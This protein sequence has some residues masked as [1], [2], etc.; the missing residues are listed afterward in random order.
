M[1]KDLAWQI[2]AGAIIV[3]VIWRLM[4]APMKIINDI[5]RERKGEY[6]LTLKG[7]NQHVNKIQDTLTE[8][9]KELKPEQALT[10]QDIKQ[11]IFWS[12]N[13]FDDSMIGGITRSVC[14]VFEVT[15]ASSIWIGATGNVKGD[16]IVLAWRLLGV[17]WVVECNGIEPDSKGKVRIILPVPETFARTLAF[18]PQDGSFSADFSEMSIEFEMKDGQHR[19]TLGYMPIGSVHTIDIPIKDH[20]PYQKLRK[21]VEW[22][23]GLG[24]DSSDKSQR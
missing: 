14:F 5:R 3:F 11:K 16:L 2:P 17:R 24:E 12:F 6:P 15:N 21:V 9:Q 8:L 23:D 20:R 7:V 18:K 1:L 4:Q 13:A 22:E 19:Y 10:I